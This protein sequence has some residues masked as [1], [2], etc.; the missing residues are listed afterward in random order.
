MVKV[1]KGG[2]TQMLLFSDALKISSTFVE[3]KKK[4]EVRFAKTIDA[5][6]PITST[7]EE[8]KAKGN[9]YKPSIYELGSLY[10]DFV[11]SN[12][13]IRNGCKNCIQLLE[14]KLSVARLC[15]IKRVV[16]NIFPI[17]VEKF[18]QCLGN[19]DALHISIVER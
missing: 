11:N 4:H 18:K 14:D 3:S 6:S 19:L 8:L 5:I 10:Q 15:K 7:F 1:K 2:T 16:P 13:K 17:G 9:D 12:E